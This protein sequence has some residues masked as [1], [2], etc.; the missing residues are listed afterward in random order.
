MV[1]LLRGLVSSILLQKAFIGAI[2][3]KESKMAKKTPK[4]EIYGTV[5]FKKHKTW[6]QTIP[7]SYL[8]LELNK[9]VSKGMEYLP[10]K[11]TIELQLPKEAYEDLLKQTENSKGK[12][13][14][15]L[16]GDLEFILNNI[17]DE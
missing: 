16:I 7:H 2:L 17:N 11:M 5:Q 1:M 10:K 9:I 4:I 8:V 14:I 6:K 12:L 13:K 3:E 15:K